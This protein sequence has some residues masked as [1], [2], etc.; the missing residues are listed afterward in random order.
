MTTE[1]FLLAHH[2]PTGPVTQK[3]IDL[4]KTYGSNWIAW[5]YLARLELEK[6]GDPDIKPW[7][8]GYEYPAKELWMTDWSKL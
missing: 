3:L 8:K 7:P 4:A 1:E 2:T 6:Q 5:L